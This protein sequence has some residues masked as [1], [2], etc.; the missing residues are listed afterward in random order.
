MRRLPSSW[1]RFSI[2]GLLVALGSFGCAGPN[3]AAAGAPRI[4]FNE[5]GHHTQQLMALGEQPVVI[6]FKAGQEVIRGS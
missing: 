4:P 3:Q 1:C 6:H 5:L 2:V